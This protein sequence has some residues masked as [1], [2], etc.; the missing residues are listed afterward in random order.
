MRAR[1]R[2]H[3]TSKCTDHVPYCKH[4]VSLKFLAL[5]RGMMGSRVG[6]SQRALY[7]EIRMKYFVIRLR[8]KGHWR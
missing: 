2:G 1:V 3:V 5:D 8:G 6:A 4:G 7:I